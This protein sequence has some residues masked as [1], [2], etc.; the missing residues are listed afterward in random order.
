MAERRIRSTVQ[1]SSRGL[2]QYGGARLLHDYGLLRFVGLAGGPV[3]QRQIQPFGCA[4]LVPREVVT[5]EEY[6]DK[7]R[8]RSIH[9]GINHGD[10]SGSA[11]LES[12]LSITEANNLG[13]GFAGDPGHTTF[14][15]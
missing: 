15:E 9:A 12:G 1:N 8:M 10:D 3:Q 11:D 6:G 7:D 14:P 4:G 2:V 5:G 13:G